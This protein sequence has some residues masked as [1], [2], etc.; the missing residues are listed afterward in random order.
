MLFKGNNLYSFGSHYLLSRMGLKLNGVNLTIVNATKYSR[1]TN[2]Q[3]NVLCSKLRLYDH[4]FL[5]VDE[6]ILTP[7]IRHGV[8]DAD[9]IDYALDY[10]KKEKIELESK[11]LKFTEVSSYT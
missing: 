7:Q 10:L 1:M 2:D 6:T 9:L 5:L 8:G 11:L 3:K 4:A